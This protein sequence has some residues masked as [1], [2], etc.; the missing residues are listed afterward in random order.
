[1]H[2]PTWPAG[3][4]PTDRGTHRWIPPIDRG[5]YNTV[6]CIARGPHRPPP[7]PTDRGLAA[8][9]PELPRICT[10]R[11]RPDRPRL[12]ESGGGCEQLRHLGMVLARSVC[13]TWGPK[14]MWHFVLLTVTE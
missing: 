14:V 12:G 11:A 2:G 4:G 10:G 5:T 6:E 13:A 1:G 7:T 8:S 9:C 3:R